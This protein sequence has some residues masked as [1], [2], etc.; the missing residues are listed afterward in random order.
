MSSLSMIPVTQI[1]TA[2][3]GIAVEVLVLAST[4]A[5]MAAIDSNPDVKT[6]FSSA[7][8]FSIVIIFIMVYLILSSLAKSA[9]IP[10]LN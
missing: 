7:Y 3:R 6:K 5:N 9:G 1:I 8:N 4:A 2:V 10:L